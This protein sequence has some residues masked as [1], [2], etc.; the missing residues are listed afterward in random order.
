MCPLTKVVYRM[1]G[2]R[3]VPNDVRSANFLTRVLV[4]RNCMSKSSPP[5]VAS[6]A[7]WCVKTDKPNDSSGLRQLISTPGRKFY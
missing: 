7:W 6:S 3:E 2:K 1:G 4:L 5:I